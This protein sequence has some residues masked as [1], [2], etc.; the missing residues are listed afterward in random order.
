MEWRPNICNFPPPRPSAVGHEHVLSLLL[1]QQFDMALQLIPSLEQDYLTFF[2]HA[3]V[4]ALKK[5]LNQSIQL[6]HR[7]FQ[8]LFFQII[9]YSLT[10]AD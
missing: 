8:Y 7:L 4:V 9:I 10:Y 3:E 1:S 2:L 5:Q 6:L